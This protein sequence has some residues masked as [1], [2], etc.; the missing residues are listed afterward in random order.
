MATVASHLRRL[1]LL[2][3]LA[4]ASCAAVDR[5]FSDLKRC[6]DRECSMLLCR[7]KAADDFSGPDCRFLSFKKGETIYVYYKLSGQRSD[8]W[9]GSV[10]SHFGYFPKDLLL[11]NHIY[12]EDELEVPTE[13]TDFV[14]FD[15]GLDAFNSYDVDKLLSYSVPAE[16]EDPAVES[17]VAE[18][19]ETAAEEVES[20]EDLDHADRDEHLAGETHEVAEDSGLANT[21]DLETGPGHEP[22]PRQEEVKPLTSG[23]AEDLDAEDAAERPPVTE[24]R[25]VPELQTT[26]GETFDA[27]TTDDEET[28]RV[29]PYSVGEDSQEPEDA[30]S[31]HADDPNTPKLLPYVEEEPHV[32]DEVKVPAEPLEEEA[33]IT[34]DSHAGSPENRGPESSMNSDSGEP[35]EAKD[36]NAAGH[37]DSEPESVVDSAGESLDRTTAPEEHVT[38]VEDHHAESVPVPTPLGDAEVVGGGER[39]DLV[40]AEQTDSDESELDNFEAIYVEQ[41]EDQ[42]DQVEILTPDSRVPE[43]DK[44]SADEFIFETPVEPA[45]DELE[46]SRHDDDQAEQ[47]DE[48]HKDV[49]LGKESEGTPEPL[50]QQKPHEDVAQLNTSE[51]S[52]SSRSP[53]EN[54][55]HN[56][57]EHTLDEETVHQIAAVKKEIVDLFAKTLE[58]EQHSE[59]PG[60]LAEREED[61]DE[62]EL[63]E[64]ENALPS[65][66]PDPAKEKE[67]VDGELEANSH[68]AEHPEEPSHT[69]DGAAVAEAPPLNYSSDANIVDNLDSKEPES[70][71][72]DEENVAPKP[73]PQYSDSVLRLTLLRNFFKEKDLGRFQEYLGLKNLFQVEAM[74]TDLDQDLKSARLSQTDH[75][76]DIERTLEGIL[77]TSENSILDEIEKM[78]DSREEKNPELREDPEM[79]DVEASILDDFQ[80]L[81]FHLRQKYSAVSDS[82]PL[83]AGS[84]P[85]AA[86]EDGPY[87]ETEKNL[88]EPDEEVPAHSQLQPN[89]MDEGPHGT[90]AGIED[91]G[92][93]RNRDSQ[94]SV[95]DPKELQRGPQAIL[96]N[97]LDVAFGFD[98]ER[99]SS[100]SL[101][102]QSVSDF[103]EEATKSDDSSPYFT[104]MCTLLRL[105]HKYLGEYA[106][107]LIASLPEEWQPGPTFHGLP[108]EP[109]IGSAAVGAL[110]FIVFFWRTILAVKGRKY[111][112][113]EKQLAEKISKLLSEKSEVLAKISELNQ[114]NQECEKQLAESKQTQKS[115][116]RENEELKDSFKKLKKCNEDMTRK[117]SALTQSITDEQK[118]KKELD[119]ILAK[120]NKTV[121]SLKQVTQS[122]KQELSKVQV[123]MDE[124]KLREDALKAEVLSF[125]K[126]NVSLKDQKKSLLRDAKMWEEKHK[127]L[128]E[129]IK[130]F[131]KSQKDLEDAIAHKENEI[132]V[133]SDCIA[134][135]RSLEVCDG[136]E[137]SREDSKVLAN[138]ESSDKNS[139]AVKIRVRQMMDVSRVKTTLSIVEDERNSYLEKMLTEQK[140]RQELEEQVQ[141][142]E[143][144]RLALDGEKHQLENQYKTLQQK[145][146]IMNEMYQQKENA[147]QQKLTQEEF[148]RREKESQLSEVDGKALKAEAELKTYKQ[149]IQE[150]Q[151]ELHKTEQSYKNQIAT[152]EKKAHENWLNARSS[153]RALVEEKRETANL[154][155]KLVEV[156]NKLAE[157]QRPL[158]KPTP[159]RPD[160]P[161]RR[162]DSYGPSPVSGGAPSPPLMFEGPGRPPS[163]PV[164][165]RNESFGPRPPSEPHGRYPDL[166][167]PVPARPDMY[168]PL[169][170]SPSSD[171]STAPAEAEGESSTQASVE[172]PEA[173]P[174]AQGPGSLLISPIRDSSPGPNMP[175]KAHGPPT[176]GPHP[177][178]PPPP[179][180]P[181]PPMLR[182]NGQPPMMP[183]GPLPYDPRFP[184]SHLY[185]PMPPRPYG[186]PP[187]FVRGPPPPRRDYPPMGPL[188]SSEFQGARDLPFLHGPPTGG[189]PLPPHGGRDF[190]GPPPGPFPPQVPRDGANL[191][192]D[193][194]PQPAPSHRDTSN[195]SVAEP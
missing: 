96:D 45:S 33:E 79:F 105:A 122:H 146:E 97:P 73:E 131:Q 71:S 65:S 48:H 56:V 52:S 94:A 14:C 114:M 121:A 55:S 124:A 116:R 139:D 103:H 135:L 20:A 160:R 70:S 12:S 82:E 34:K 115:T 74:F 136:T 108:W 147:L 43:E 81:A 176:G 22:E 90:D 15:S 21:L 67:E 57:S 158:F 159:G 25:A 137:Q 4:S 193:C 40:D 154:R 152:Q 148:D 54:I 8:V 149:R 84:P 164:G 163:A 46:G 62:E 38:A 109:V 175:L 106:E 113:T 157:F 180:G 151:E 140:A 27:V 86:A 156:S 41:V 80:E 141:K 172:A 110:T 155:Q 171:G 107:L 5:R 128:N 9:A 142:L 78:L 6:A 37:V 92:G 60:E 127:E 99:P 24:G 98:V 95:K 104:E 119:D 64:D 53:S 130:V 29:T 129:K 76:E 187:P 66:R 111:Q 51:V 162:G 31:G 120:T 186:P 173:V 126:E 39:T 178:G 68:T 49:L 2:L 118:R 75:A 59:D 87:K 35:E 189:M 77:E 42:K 192:T 123:L 138:G 91:D 23:A 132:G 125:E 28:I 169:T 47:K 174:K 167:H 184:P 30:E 19:P 194:P 112:L 190:Q 161:I 102:S 168:A 166:G 18:D 3:L 101:E 36:S 69:E 17:T 11:I 153:E 165:R 44:H 134:E 195:P 16:R 145:L 133:L 117:V 50:A 58:S 32:E 61:E 191:K 72:T 150:I 85:G 179:N 144:D 185:G 10:G 83:A 170:S 143:H 177:L 7:G 183:P 182:P 188:H 1:L 89:A 13:E 93:H 26:F 181:V 88:T 100:G 63:L